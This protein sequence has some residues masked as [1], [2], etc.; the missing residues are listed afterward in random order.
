[1]RCWVEGERGRGVV[2]ERKLEVL[3][4]PLLSRGLVRS[5]GQE[6][7]LLTILCYEILQCIETVVNSICV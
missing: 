4:I 1:M 6:P 3:G 5:P 7:T 2:K